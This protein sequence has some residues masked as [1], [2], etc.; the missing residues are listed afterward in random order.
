MGMWLFI[1]AGINYSVVSWLVKPMSHCADI[2]CR[3]FRSFLVVTEPSDRG[4]LLLISGT[5]CCPRPPVPSEY[6]CCT[7]KARHW[8]DWSIW[9]ALLAFSATISTTTDTIDMTALALLT[10]THKL[11]PKCYH[12]LIDPVDHSKTPAHFWQLSHDHG[13]LH[14]TAS[15]LPLRCERPTSRPCTRSGWSPQSA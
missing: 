4:L 9:S 8:Y 7:N 2:F 15:T 5:M 14:T 6:E 3:C 11:S 12:D 1:H 10:I 13:T